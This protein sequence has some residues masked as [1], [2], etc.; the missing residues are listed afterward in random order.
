MS[1]LAAL[2]A[3]LPAAAP[4]WL[5]P[6]SPLWQSNGG[7]ARLLGWTVALSLLGHA[8]LLLNLSG[9]RLNEARPLILQASLRQAP[10]AHPGQSASR[11]EPSL[12]ASQPPQAQRLPP[13]HLLTTPTGAPPAISS[14]REG[15]AGPAIKAVATTATASPEAAAPS[16]SAAAPAG[17]ASA[18]AAPREAAASAPANDGAALERY[19]RGLAELLA[20][21]QQYPRLAAMRGWEGEVQ[22]Q[23]RVAR[24]GNI[25]DLQLAH[26]SGFAVLDRQALQL[27]AA[28]ALPPLPE[29]VR[30]AEIQLI[31]PIHFKLNKAT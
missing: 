20:R 16:G 4:A 11:P 26:S 9:P 15:A 22:V 27:L 19:G 13:R 5:P 14:A 8:A 30:E 10:A 29:S 17:S 21:Q 12:A 3:T 25:V 24:K 31:V 2:P 7:S 6:S 28:T 1:R 18:P 23:V